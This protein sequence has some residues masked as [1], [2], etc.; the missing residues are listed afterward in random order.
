M[1]QLVASSFPVPSHFDPGEADGMLGSLLEREDLDAWPVATQRATV[2]FEEMLNHALLSAFDPNGPGEPEAHL[3]VQRV[4]Y[5]INRLQLFW[6]DALRSYRNE[7]SPWLLGIREHV[8][9]E[10]QRWEARQ[11]DVAAL[12]GLDVRAA[13]RE[14]AARDVA[15]PPSEAGRFFRDVAGI[16]A[17][18]RLLEIASLD[19]LVEASQL[20]RTLGGVSTPIHATMTRLLLEEYGGGRPARKH[21]SFFATMLRTLDLD[22]TPEAYLDRVP[23][24]V[25]ASINQSFLLSDRKRWFLRYV[26]GL[27]YTEVSVPAAFACYRDAAL[28]LGLPPEARAYWELHIK[29]DARHGPW[30]LD[31]VA[32][33]LVERYPEDAWELVLGYDQQRHLSARAAEAVARAAMD[34]DAV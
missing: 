12:Y 15:P 31:D 20:S 11:I 13:L 18:R 7:R 21:S 22:A 32:L 4:L 24:P 30:M 16:A 3:L 19:A 33:P 5:R 25:L 26:G 14:R 29:E 28:R 17:Y 8:E 23:W 6:Y 2:A 1:L 34:A 27:L 10:W 9:W